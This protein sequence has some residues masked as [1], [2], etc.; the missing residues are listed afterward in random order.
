MGSMPRELAYYNTQMFA[1]RVMPHLKSKFSEYEDKWIRSRCRNPG[2]RCPRA[3][4]H[5]RNP[6][7]SRELALSSAGGGAGA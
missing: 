3:R 1:E 2:A 5:P 6:Q 4:P 7:E